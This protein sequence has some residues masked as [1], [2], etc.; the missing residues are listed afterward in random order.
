MQQYINPKPSVIRFI[1]KDDGQFPNSSL[2][3]LIYKDAITLPGKDDSSIF[4]EIFKSNNWSNS[5][6]NGIFDYHHYHSI[7]HEVLGVYE[8]T[9]NVQFGGPQGV[10]E[11]I[12]KGDVIIIPAG[13][14]HKCNSASEDF[15]C[16][17]AYPE[18]MDYDIKKGEPSDRPKA[19]ENINNVKLPDT[20]PMY[21]LDGL[22]I[23]NWEMW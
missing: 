5:W 18:G 21:G 19:D 4:K 2:F 8:G 7:T 1:L 15:K 14:A 23:L 3:L 16:I 10:S 12:T 6:L 9:A 20:D 22:L 11:D 17:G 13:V